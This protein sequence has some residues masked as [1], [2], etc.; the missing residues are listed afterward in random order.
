MLQRLYIKDFAI[1]DELEIIFDSGFQVIT[2]ETGAGKSILVGAIGFLCGE[3]G[4]TEI[5]RAG[6][7][8]A[9]MEGEFV[10]E[11][12]N[13]PDKILNSFE[14]EPSEN[15]LILRREINDRGISRAFVNDSP[16]KISALAT[17]SDY[18]ID[19]HGQHQHQ[20][21]L[22]PETHIE[23]LDAFG[24][25]S[26]VLLK[27]KQALAKYQQ[28]IQKLNE[29]KK[30]YDLLREKQDLFK[31]QI[32][33]LDKAR[34]SSGEYNDLEQE[35]KILEN[36]ELLFEKARSV[37]DNLYNSDES[38][39]K[40]VAT[41]TA[42]LKQIAAIDGSFNMLLKNLE[43]ARVTIEEIGLECEQYRTKLE[44]DPGRLEDIH[45]RLAELDWLIKK[46][47]VNSVNDLL[48]QYGELKRQI[49]S[50]E[51]FQS[52]IEELNL[53]IKRDTNELQLI[54]VYLS[55]QRKKA[56]SVFQTEMNT[57]L[58]SVGLQNSRFEINFNYQESEKGEVE[59]NEKKCLLNETGVD[60]VE[61]QVGLNI[62]EPVKPLHKV[63][64]G[65]EVSRIMLCIKSLL[66]DSD[67]ID[68]L[69]FDEI[70]SGI[71]GKFAQIVGKRMRQMS[72]KHQLI[73]ITHLPQ[74][75]AQGTRH[76][77]VNKFETNGRTCV[78]VIELN[79]DQ[80]IEDIAKLLGG[81]NI[82]PGSIANAREL[83]SEIN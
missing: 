71:S 82:T 42:N 7:Q 45:N 8:K 48:H 12:S 38:V 4:N 24:Q 57:A 16:V 74:I 13:I 28:D 50:L 67:K 20:S 3:R 10:F 40:N 49:V 76:Y 52:D 11:N 15:H 54:A 75:A 81:E 72:Q 14:I 80:R 51:N 62:G 9:I 53:N 61:F 43:A 19:L 37:A 63:A 59:I 33:E 78:E 83:L 5:I 39:L 55:D 79:E 47:H 27:Y 34:L 23:Y 60:L 58:H 31:F 17:I 6:A 66:A 22:R 46:Y 64:S 32:D 44:F 35:R 65:G 18:L 70:D 73:V 56:A 36:S 26:P 1:V 77:S 68:T 29:L 30:Y 21:L 41:A 69:V 25:L 2:G